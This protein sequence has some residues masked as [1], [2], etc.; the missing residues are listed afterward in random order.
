MGIRVQ[1]VYQRL[2]L[3]AVSG[4]LMMGGWLIPVLLLGVGLLFP[5]EV[6]M[7][8]SHSQPL[9][10]TLEYSALSLTHKSEIFTP[11]QNIRR[12]HFQHQSEG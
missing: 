10:F 3:T 7:S 12:Q 5:V 4:V 1:L 2:A 8:K 11:Q 6:S 9:K